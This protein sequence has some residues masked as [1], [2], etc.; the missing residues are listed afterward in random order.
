LVV[1]AVMSTIWYGLWAAAAVAAGVILA[2]VTDQE[3]LWL[4]LGQGLMISLLY[5]QVIPV[6]MVSTGASLDLKRLLVYPIPAHR[7]FGLEVLLRLSTGVEM[8]LV[9]IGASAGLM[10]NPWRGNMSG[11]SGSCCW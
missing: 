1:S 8:I 10:A 11:R 2:G 3:R 6:L 9:L 5:W 7:L 4:L